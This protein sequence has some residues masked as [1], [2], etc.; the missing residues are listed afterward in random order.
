MLGRR[1]L[2]AGLGGGTLVDSAA[3]RTAPCG[4]AA[5][6]AG[7]VFT[8]VPANPHEVP[9][10]R[11]IAI[12]P[13]PNMHA[14]WGGTGRDDAGHLWFGVCAADDG[15]SAHLM[16]LDP[17]TGGMRD[18]GD[19]LSALEAAGRL[20]PREGQIKI[21]TKILQASDGHM[22]FASTDEE[23]EREDGGAPPRWGSHLWRFLRLG[24]RWDHLMTVPEG[25][26]AAAISGRWVYAL[27]LWDHVLYRYD[28]ESGE[29]KRAVVG[30][31]GGH[32]SRN[33]LVDHR[34]HVY[35]PRVRQAA[36]GALSASLVE[37]DTGL[38]EV[39]ATPLE[40][41]ADGLDPGRAHGI[42]SFTQL[43]DGS[44]V[45]TSSI[46][47]LHRIVP[48][49]YGAAAVESLGWFD[50]RGAA[51]TS[52]L[53]TWDGECHLVGPSDGAP[54]R[55]SPP[56]ALHDWAWVVFDLRTRTSRAVAFPHGLGEF[57]LLYGSDTRDDSGRFY[58]AGRRDRRAPVILQIETPG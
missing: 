13:F 11:E 29:V 23:G 30:S 24:G 20:R 14:I 25:L 49:R 22:Y 19:V 38:D 36:G 57:A 9:R 18:R 6:A 58:V 27:G 37:Y 34:G 56:A 2:L 39:A 44:L 40:H 12:P 31:V 41:Y 53:F 16:E 51:Y 8:K 7:G 1:L 26:T 48:K 15:H 54:F 43:A 21:H 55:S 3:S 10:I 4:S 46:G 45:F 52:C 50:P 42:L 35:A 47:F 5:R 28:T 32:M 33:L 17:A